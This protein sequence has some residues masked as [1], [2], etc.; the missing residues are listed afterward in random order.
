MTSGKPEKSDM[1]GPQGTKDG[2][3]A[4]ASLAAVGKAVQGFFDALGGL[5][6]GL[7]TGLRERHAALVGDRQQLYSVIA[8]Q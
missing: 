8:G 5:A 7:D 3:V 6:E 4:Q 1:S 2:I